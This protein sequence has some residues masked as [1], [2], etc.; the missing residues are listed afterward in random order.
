MCCQKERE[1]NLASFRLLPRLL[2]LRPAVPPTHV[3]AEAV[4]A[5]PFLEM[6]S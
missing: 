4:E 6:R 5:E 2:P 3:C 1:G